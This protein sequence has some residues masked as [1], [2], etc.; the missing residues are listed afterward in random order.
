MLENNNLKVCRKL[1]I[2]DLRFHKLKTVLLTAAIALVTGLYTF[3]FLLGSAIEESFLTNYEWSYGSTSHILYYGLTEHQADVLAGHGAVKSAVKLVSLGLLT[4]DPLEYRSVKLAV[5][6]DEYAGSVLSMPTQGRMP[7]SPDEIAMD[8]FTMDSLGIPHEIGAPVKI[9]WT[10]GGTAS[11]ENSNIVTGGQ[12]SSYGIDGSSR[13][14]EFTLCG[15][16]SSSTNFKE[17]CA[18]ITP[19]RARELLPGYEDPQARNIT[20]GVKLHQPGDLELQAEEMLQ[21]LGLGALPY[22]TNLAYNDTRK[23]MAESKAVPYYY[24]NIIVVLC[25]FLM[26]YNII[27]IS[28]GQDVRFFGQ[29]KALGMTPR[30]VRRI[31]YGQ[32]GYLTAMGIPCGWL[33]GFGLYLCITPMII[34]GVEGNSGL[35]FFH[36]WPFAAAAAVSWL[37]AFAAY[38]IPAGF[39]GR[40][41][42]AEAVRYVA[43]AAAAGKGRGGVRKKT[44]LLRMAFQSLKRGKAGIVVS[45]LSLF[46]A[47]VVLCGTYMQYISYDESLYLQG[48]ALCD[49]L[50]ADGSAATVYQ[51][52]NPKSRSLTE[53]M[54]REL[55]A[56][57][58]VLEF[59][60]LKTVEVRLKAEEELADAVLEYY[61][62]IGAMDIPRRQEMEGEPDWC[63]GLNRLEQEREYTALIVGVEGLSLRKAVEEVPANSGAYDKELFR[64]G[65]YVVASGASSTDGVST[66]PA[67]G[68]VKI[69]GREFTVMASVYL[70]PGLLSGNNS[71]EAQFALTYYLPMDIFEELFPEAGIRQVM[72]NL[73]PSW[74]KSFEAYLDQFETGLNKGIAVTKKSFY[75]ENFRSGIVTSTLMNFIVAAV[76]M[77]IGFLNFANALF[78]RTLMRQKEFAVYESLGMTRK[79]LRRLVLLEGLLY[80]GVILAVLVP[81]V[82]AVTWWG[83]PVLFRSMNTWCI[84]YR[85]SLAPLWALVPVFTAAAVGVPM[86]CLGLVNG[87]SVVERLRIVE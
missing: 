66:L 9:E 72:V 85:Y 51:R 32:A 79:Q 25:G 69:Q 71:L 39:A 64:T 34:I 50:V 40:I 44:T 36:V 2:R 13:V 46:L 81:A 82:W 78:T 48:M 27:H 70:Q 20:L 56:R 30:Q 5:A 6:D 3:S 11:A 45:M 1:V 74:Q 7:E 49:Y 31:L 63:A 35:Y 42:P 53:D 14:S 21:E 8:E 67:G 86:G 38:S 68:K 47:L 84:I 33:L 83:M 87:E 19:E 59:G 57:P 76:L 17:A 52:Y 26:I 29:V 58:G 23:S 18:W 80:A 24:V 62:G 12:G 54:A 10:S 77:L 37:T 28:V 43:A 73:D 41:T 75:Q 15:Y 4:D 16:W 60:R 61:N 55:A 65:E 22:T